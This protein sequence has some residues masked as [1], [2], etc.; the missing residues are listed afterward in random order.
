MNNTFDR[1]ITKIRNNT[2]EGNSNK[3]EINNSK[4]KN[5]KIRYSISTNKSIRNIVNNN[6]LYKKVPNEQKIIKKTLTQKIINLAPADSNKLFY[7]NSIKNSIIKNNPKRKSY[8]FF[9]TN[10]QNFSREFKK[11]KTQRASYEFMKIKANKFFKKYNLKMNENDSISKKKD[12]I[13]NR[14]TNTDL[15]KIEKNIKNVLKNMKIEIEKKNKLAQM[16]ESISPKFIRNRLA[17]TPNLKIFSFKNNRNKHKQIKNSSL[18]IE[19]NILNDKYDFFSKKFNKIR[20]RSFVYTER[21]KKRIMKNLKNKIIKLSNERLNIINITTD[22]DT[23]ND[24]NLK[25]FSFLPN[26]NFIFIFDLLLIIANLYI[27]IFFPLNLAKNKEIGKNDSII[28]DFFCYLVDLIYIFDL[29]LGFF[30]A[31]YNYEMKIIRNNRKIIYCYLKNYF[32]FDLLEAIPIFSLIKIF[33]KKNN[34]IYFELSN[35]KLN[36]II[37]FFIKPFKIFK[38]IGKKQNMALEDFYT[39]LSESYYLENLVIFLIYFIIFFLFVH[40][41]VCFHIYI[42]LRSYPNWIIHI[43]LINGTFLEKYL[44]SFY[45]MVTTMTT[46]GYGDIVCISPIERIYHIILLVIGTLLYTFLVS[47]IGNYLR[48]ESREQIKLSKDLNILENIRISYPSMPFKLYSKIKNHLF[49]IYKKR[50]KTGISVLLNGVP[51]AIKND[52]LFKIYSNVINNFTIFKDIKNSNFIH[53]MLTSFIPIISKKEEIIILEGEIIQ[54]IIFVKDGRLSMEIAIDLN[55]P[56]KSLQ[57]YKENNFIGIS[58]QEEVKNHNFINRVNSLIN[59][60]K[61]NYNDLKIE[62]ET[63]LYGNKNANINSNSQSNN[64]ISVDLGRMDFSRNEINDDDNTNYQIIKIID[65]R[66]NEHFGDVF[67]FSEQPSPFTVKSKSRIAELLLL[68]KNDALKLSKNFPNIWRRIQDKS[69]HNLVSIK[70][71]TFKIIKQYYITHF[72]S[73]NKNEKNFVL[74]LDATKNSGIFSSDIK[75]SFILKIKEKNE[76]K[77]NNKSIDLNNSKANIKPKINKLFLI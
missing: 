46:V 43:N 11:T 38:I 4:T 10:S 16:T 17:S 19:K 52:L 29:F 15:N 76:E 65:F 66:K 39:Y 69:F 57:K 67:I 42:T 74:D 34:N 23:D 12:F 53:Q 62:I 70:R 2:L 28:N 35:S 58:R 40:L 72:T 7:D 25:G 21:F 8:D 73:K 55:D 54:N 18:L 13:L 75:Q 27:F 47:K 50:K 3:N 63:F 60:K 56:Y 24:K 31:Y 14:S 48:D 68:R 9:K 6:L 71:L 64:G 22:N 44:T 20:N 59:N 36:I 61:R 32:I 51:D 37:I 26:S 33:M 30:R 45:F 41:F 5:V 77:N 1:S 49:S